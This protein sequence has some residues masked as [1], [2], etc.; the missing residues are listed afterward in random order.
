MLNF[1]RQFGPLVARGSVLV[2]ARNLILS[3]RH[4]E[5]GLSGIEFAMIA[6]VLILAFIATADFGLAIYAKMEV[7]NAAQAGTQYASVHGYTSDT[8]S[9]AVISATS[10]SGL[11]ASPAPTE[12]CGCPSTSGVSTATCGTYCA[13]GAYAGTYVSASATN[14]YST[15]VAYPGIPS[16]YTFQSTSTVRIK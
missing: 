15:I 7:E 16:S 3:A 2:K 4:S 5:E 10:L 14:T 11:T 8:V 1:A 12:F 13:N 6:P 9:S